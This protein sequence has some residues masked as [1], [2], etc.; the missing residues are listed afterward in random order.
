MKCPVCPTRA[1]WE[2]SRVCVL[3]VVD[4]CRFVHHFFIMSAWDIPCLNRDELEG[5][6]WTWFDVYTPRP[7]YSLMRDEQLAVRADMTSQID[8]Q[9][10]C[11]LP[12]V[13]ERAVKYNGPRPHDPQDAYRHVA[14]HIGYDVASHV[15][16]LA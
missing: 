3:W 6:A 10:P 7:F 15:P 8:A 5:Y 1:A 12:W 16:P 9:G 11:P 4:G 13:R 14:Q 2:K